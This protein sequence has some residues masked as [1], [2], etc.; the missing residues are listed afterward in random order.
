MSDQLTRLTTKT[1]QMDKQM[2]IKTQ[3]TPDSE[4]IIEK[5]QIERKRKDEIKY[6][7]LQMVCALVYVYVCVC[8]INAQEK[9]YF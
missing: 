5:G 8:K 4:R 3:I 1:K 6:L 2:M 7:W 9:F